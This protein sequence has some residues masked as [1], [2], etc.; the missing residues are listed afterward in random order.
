MLV[1]LVVNAAVTGMLSGPH[2][3]YQNRIIWLTALAPLMVVAEL[4]ARVGRQ[5]QGGTP[6][7]DAVP[8]LP[9][10]PATASVAEAMEAASLSLLPAS[11]T[12]KTV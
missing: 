4:C 8:G 1:C 7:Q 9:G 6:A 2:D 3:R 12:G 5:E 10:L 11:G